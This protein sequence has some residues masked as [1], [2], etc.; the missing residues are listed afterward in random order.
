MKK[1]LISSLFMVLCFFGVL[2]VSGKTYAYTNPIN[3]IYGLGY[4]VD[5][6]EGTY[7]D[8]LSVKISAPIFN[9]SWLSSL[10]LNR[11][12]INQTIPNVISQSTFRD[13]SMAFSANAGSYW[14]L[15]GSY[16]LFT[17][18]LAKGFS[19]NLEST[20]ESYYSQHFFYKTLDVK[21]Y[22]LALPNY[23]S[24]ISMYK[25]NLHPDFI[26][27][28][29]KLQ[30]NQ[31]SYSDF[32]NIYGTHVIANSV[33]GGRLEMF[34]SILSNQKEFT[35]TVRNEIFDQLQLG[36]IGLGSASASANFSISQINGLTTSG[37]EYL[38]KGIA[39][40]GQPFD[41]SYQDQFSTN[42]SN[43]LS[44][45][46]GDEVMISYGEDGLIPL[47][48]FVPEYLSN[49]GYGLAMEM[50]NYLSS[51]T[52]QYSSIFNAAEGF[53]N[54]FSTDQK[55]LRAAEYTI[56]DSGRFYQSYDLI[57]FINSYGIDLQIM[58]LLG[59]NNVEVKIDLNV[60][61]VAD[62]YQYIF[63]YDG[64]ST[65]AN[66]LRE[67]RF[68]HS[69][70]VKNTTWGVHSFDFTGIPLTTDLQQLVIR[71]GASGL[72]SDDWINKDLKVQFIFTK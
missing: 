22:S 67:Q 38:F 61:E 18:G 33:Y 14:S 10:T 62:G 66:L 27:N 5:A 2:S 49:V 71:Y 20:Y 28:L 21:R 55:V 54:T 15:S 30:N 64:T 53:G 51:K 3:Q 52:V 26:A 60:R 6:G 63:L 19:M 40:G 35:S 23:A 16:D 72:F 9:E 29:E 34:Y 8:P 24:N 56:T 17:L 69:P 4:S 45:I 32:Y 44:S 12:D 36:I 46:D 1:V 70:N 25:Q 68:E 50:N 39:I 7:A 65:Y 57:D 47:Y 31:M 42:Y 41:V 43:W 48:N 59:Y 37:S 13:V 58:R 11:I